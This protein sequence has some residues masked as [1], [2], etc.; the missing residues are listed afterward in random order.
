[1]HLQSSRTPLCRGMLCSYL[2]SVQTRVR[3]DIPS[4]WS[5]IKLPCQQAERESI[6]SGEDLTYTDSKSLISA[7]SEGLRSSQVEYSEH[8]ELR[9]DNGWVRSGILPIISYIKAALLKLFNVPDSL[10][11]FIFRSHS[12]K[13]TD[14]QSRKYNLPTTQTRTSEQQWLDPQLISNSRTPVDPAALSIPNSGMKTETR[15]GQLR[16]QSP[17]V[18]LFN[19]WHRLDM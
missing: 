2:Y 3:V 16:T 17:L 5:L 4:D 9:P 1:M 12:N 11:S 18:R 7:T 6:C 13:H 10:S 8:G 15:F 14:N 19:L